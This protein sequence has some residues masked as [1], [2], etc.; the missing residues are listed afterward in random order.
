MGLHSVNTAGHEEDFRVCNKD[1]A[2]G[3]N[4][5]AHPNPLADYPVRR[6]PPAR[7][8]RR[9]F[10]DRRSARL[11]WTVGKGNE[12]SEVPDS[13]GIRRQAKNQQGGR[14]HAW[15]NRMVSEHSPFG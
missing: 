7:P 2:F 15:A 6:G 1:K 14:L 5:W 3:G 4:G 9:L 10:D 13:T 11:V 12:E 8:I